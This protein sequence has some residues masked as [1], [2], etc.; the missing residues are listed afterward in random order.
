MATTNR[1][2]LDLVVKVVA[3]V[4]VVAVVGHRT[5]NSYK[6]L[7][8]AVAAPEVVR[9]T[10]EEAVVAAVVAGVVRHPPAVLPV[11]VVSPVATKLYTAAPTRRAPKA[12]VRSAASETVVDD[13]AG[14]SALDD[15]DKAVAVEE[16]EEEDHE[17]PVHHHAASVQLL[18]VVR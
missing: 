7:A 10:H 16:V 13:A 11:A 8:V 6:V 17:A 9:S 4:D 2:H 15:L 1:V 3:S 18:L 5:S 14:R 12:E